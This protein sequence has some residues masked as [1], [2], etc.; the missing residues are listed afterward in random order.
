MKKLICLILG[1]NNQVVDSEYK[2]YIVIECQRCKK[3]QISTFKI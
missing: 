2:E 3:V 1:H